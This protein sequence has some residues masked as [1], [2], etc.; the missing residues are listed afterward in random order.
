MNAGHSGADAL[1][2]ATLREDAS[3]AEVTFTTC[4]RGKT[5][6]FGPFCG[7]FDIGSSLRSGGF[8]VI[9]AAT[10]VSDIG[11][12]T[13]GAAPSSALIIGFHFK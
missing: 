2:V 4:P 9:N 6:G 13:T 10:A 8:L 5:D 12:D 7:R 3:A 11:V 1:G